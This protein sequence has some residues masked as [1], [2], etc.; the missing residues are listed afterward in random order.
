VDKVKIINEM[1]GDIVVQVG[2]TA[3]AERTVSFQKVIDL[4][5]LMKEISEV[6]VEELIIKMRK[7]ED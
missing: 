4:G 1:E 2:V 7:K 5:G 3:Y 6:K